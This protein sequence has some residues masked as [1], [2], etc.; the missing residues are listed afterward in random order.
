MPLVNLKDMLRHARTNGYAVGAYDVVDCS[1]LAAVIAGAEAAQ[2]PV[3]V[4]FSESHFAHYDFQVL[5]AAAEVATKKATVPIALFLD[6]GSSLESAVAAIRYGAN[7]VMVD[8]SHLSFDDNLAAMSTAVTVAHAVGVPV[9]G[10]LGCVPGNKGEEAASHRD[11]V[12]LTSPE[13]A[14]IYVRSTGVDFLAVSVGTIHGR[15]HSEPHLDF[16][17][18]AAI[19]DAVGIP[20]VI[21]GGTGL[22]DEQFQALAARGVAKINYYTALSDLAT[23]AATSAMESIQAG[24]TAGM[25]A[26]RLALANEVSRTCKVFG[27]AGRAEAVLASCHPWLGVQ[28]LLLSKG[29]ETADRR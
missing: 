20:L 3:I 25:D 14:A 11:E 15:L 22:S 18:L 19:S 6:H 17:R 12:R 4:S 16:D 2:A 10:E 27:A 28:N 13:E 9:E 29:A 5:M 26:V 7:G 1:F 24:Y 23:A 21:H 8:T